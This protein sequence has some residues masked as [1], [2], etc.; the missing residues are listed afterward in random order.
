MSHTEGPRVEQ[1]VEPRVE[2]GG[3]PEEP[4][5]VK[6]MNV[7]TPGGVFCVRVGAEHH[8]L[9]SNIHAKIFAMQNISG[10]FP[11]VPSYIYL[12]SY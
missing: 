11:S 6:E 8:T 5:W 3:P 10:I 1:R 7:L 4:G 9:K 12:T 2:P